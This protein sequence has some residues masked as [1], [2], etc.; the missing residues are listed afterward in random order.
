MR[1]LLAEDE[2]L[3]GF[4]LATELR[5]K[6]I[7]V[8]GPLEN[9]SDVI[10]SARNCEVDVA[11]LDINLHGK[12]VYPAADI[13]LSRNV[14]VVFHTAYGDDPLLARRY[15]DVAIC[16]KPARTSDLINAL[17]GAISPQAC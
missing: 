6:G 4:Q 14:P 2:G 15:P 5:S 3:V 10:E 16:T 8:V 9:L 1:I 7:T 11:L 13:L 12:E 17:H